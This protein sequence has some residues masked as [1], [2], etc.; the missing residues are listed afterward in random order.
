MTKDFIKQVILLFCYFTLINSQVDTTAT[1]SDA[2]RTQPASNVTRFPTS[3]TTS[4]FEPGLAPPSL[5]PIDEVFNMTSNITVI[6]TPQLPSLNRTDVSVFE[7]I[8]RNFFVDRK[9]TNLS[10]DYFVFKTNY[11]QY[12][13]C[14]EDGSLDLSNSIGVEELWIPSRVNIDSEQLQ[15]ILVFR[16]LSGRLLGLKN[17]LSFDCRD[18]LVQPKNYFQPIRANTTT[19]FLGID[20][21]DSIK[22]AFKSNNTGYLGI[23]NKKILLLPEFNQSV[24]FYPSA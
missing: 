7:L 5:K 23:I 16:S 6:V 15:R 17:D 24:V 19:G 13:S 1:P 14:R 20:R 2:N 10:Q 8:P 9:G 22:I 21:N 3:N 18:K 4:P 11:S 12:L